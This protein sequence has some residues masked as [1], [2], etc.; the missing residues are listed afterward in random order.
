MQE[1]LVE[2]V[3]CKMAAILSKP[4]CVNT[5]SLNYDNELLMQYITRDQRV[6]MM[7]QRHQAGQ[8][9]RDE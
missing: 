2:N 7:T 3:V 5:L 6:K 1:T 9:L 4:K 8:G